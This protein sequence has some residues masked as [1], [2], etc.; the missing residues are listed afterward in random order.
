MSAVPVS[1]RP[2]VVRVDL[3]AVRHNCRLVRRRLADAGAAVMPTL[4]ADASGHG[5]VPIAR[6]LAEEGVEALAVGRIEA[7]LEVRALI[8]QRMTLED[9]FIQVTSTGGE[10]IQ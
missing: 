8:P 2:N 5:L 7:G 6:V 9:F 3:A 1:L 10:Q 4:R